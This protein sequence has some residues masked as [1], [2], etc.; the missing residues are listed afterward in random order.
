MPQ[1]RGLAGRPT[2]AGSAAAPTPAATRLAAG[3]SDRRRRAR[4]RRKPAGALRETGFRVIRLVAAIKQPS[5]LSRVLGMPRSS[6]LARAPRSHSRRHQDST[7]AAAEG[8][9]GGCGHCAATGM[10]PAASSRCERGRDGSAGRG[11]RSAPREGVPSQHP[12]YTPLTY[13]EGSATAMTWHA[14]HTI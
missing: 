14:S 1:R 13:K 5:H 12:T 8:R 10:A 3:L 6:V 7:D 11:P 2:V 4:I 9:S